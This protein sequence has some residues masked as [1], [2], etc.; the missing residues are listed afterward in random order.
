MMMKKMLC[1]LLACLMLLFVLPAF[2]EEQ[3]PLSLFSI[4]HGRRDEKRIAITVDD[5]FDLEW[6]WKIRDMFHEFGI[7]GTFFP[8]GVQL[9]EEDRE[10]WQKVLDYGNEIGSHNMGHYKMGGSNAWDIISALGR[11]QE[12]LDATLGYHYQVNA[13]RPP[14]GNTSDENGNGK[15]FRNAVQI[16]GYEHVVLWE[17]SQ[18]ANPD[19]AYSKTQNGSILLFHARKKDHDCMKEVIPRLLADGYEFV[20]ISELLEFGENE[21]SPE[22]YV[23]NK[24]DY[25]KKKNR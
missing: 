16:F 15:T 1:V 14:F 9:H 6:T 19:L 21:I 22:P 2:G 11:F 20:T 23:Y 24:A 3:D 17:V 4:R 25:E 10:E 5:S 18:A 13:F 8:V 7:V 12:T